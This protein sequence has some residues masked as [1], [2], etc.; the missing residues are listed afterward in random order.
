[1]GGSAGRVLTQRVRCRPRAP[2]LPPT[3]Q[4]SAVLDESRSVFRRSPGVFVRETRAYHPGRGPRRCRELP[5]WEGYRPCH[6]WCP[7]SQSACPALHVPAVPGSCTGISPRDWPVAARSSHVALVAV[8]EAEYGA[9]RC[10][11]VATSGHAC[12]LADKPSLTCAIETFGL[13]HRACA[14]MISPAAGTTSRA[15]CH[16]CCLRIL[17]LNAFIPRLPDLGCRGENVSVLWN[18]R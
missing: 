9:C 8:R 2:D 16:P 4:I 11:C 7:T 13:L 3:S 18:A 10:H 14:R 17:A 1:M 6:L 5:E 12:A 15:P